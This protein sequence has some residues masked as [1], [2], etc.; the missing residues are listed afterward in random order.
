MKIEALH[1]FHDKKF[2]EEWS[3]RF[4]PTVDRLSLFQMILERLDLKNDQQLRILELGI[5]PGYLAEYILSKYNNIIYEGLDFSEAMID[6]AKCRLKTK[7]NN[8][9]LTKADLTMDAWKNKIKSAPQNIIST[10]TLHDLLSK[11]NICNVYKTAYEILPPKGKVINGDFIK[12]EHSD[13][14]YENGR[15]NPSE[16]INL[17]K[18]CGFREVRCLQIFEHNVDAPSTSNNYGCFIAIK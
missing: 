7:E 13:I 6:I 8:L 18:S 16:H 10:W 12:P 1:N 2:S 17:L 5:G 15:I 11:Q 9:I 3:N 14:E 4:K